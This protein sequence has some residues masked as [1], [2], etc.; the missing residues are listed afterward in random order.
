MRNNRKVTMTP[1]SP[2]MYVVIFTDTEGREYWWKHY[3][4]MGS[5][6]GYVRNKWGT[7]FNVAH[8]FVGWRIE[9]WHFI[10]LQKGRIVM[11]SLKEHAPVSITRF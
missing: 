9:R 6:I 5:A 1:E 3:K 10:T 8:R 7:M 11:A 4:R 2:H